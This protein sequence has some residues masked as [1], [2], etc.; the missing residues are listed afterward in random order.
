M[1]GSKK[2]PKPALGKRGRPVEEGRRS[3]GIPIPRAPK[4]AKLIVNPRGQKKGR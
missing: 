2:V 4:V 1:T 3:F